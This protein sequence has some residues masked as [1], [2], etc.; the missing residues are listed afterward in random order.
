MSMEGY[1]AA[2]AAPSIK[3]QDADPPHDPKSSL[4]QPDNGNSQPSSDPKLIDVEQAPPA[5]SSP[6]PARERTEPADQPAQA[7]ILEPEAT[8]RSSAADRAAAREDRINDAEQE[9]RNRGSIPPREEATRNQPA[10]LPHP[11]R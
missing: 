6:I 9:A 11:R 7:S 10:S 1:N 5:L 8:K 4:D 3:G 2:G